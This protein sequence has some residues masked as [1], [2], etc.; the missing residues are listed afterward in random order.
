MYGWKEDDRKRGNHMK[1]TAAATTPTLV[2]N[3]G[4]CCCGL[5]K[6]EKGDG[7]D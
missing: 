2:W 3:I 7:K 4:C 5:E 6:G 1:T